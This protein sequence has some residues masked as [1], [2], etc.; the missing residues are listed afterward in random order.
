M[1]LKQVK[2]KKRFKF[3]N[4]GLI[5]LIVSIF[6]SVF[7]AYLYLLGSVDLSNKL[8]KVCILAFSISWLMVIYG[9]HAKKHKKIVIE[10]TKKESYYSSSE[11]AYHYF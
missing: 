11:N 7:S 2:V 3:E 8:A 4:L 9:Q 5:G 10:V 1:K 6:L